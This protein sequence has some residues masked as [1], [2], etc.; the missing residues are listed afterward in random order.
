MNKNGV[1]FDVRDMTIYRGYIIDSNTYYDVLKRLDTLGESGE[2]VSLYIREAKKYLVG[3]LFRKALEISRTMD[4]T[5]VK[6]TDGNYQY[7][8]DS[9]K[10][11]DLGDVLDEFEVHGKEYGIPKPKLDR[12]RDKLNRVIERRKN[13]YIGLHKMYSGENKSNG[14]K[15]N[16]NGN[17]HENGG[18]E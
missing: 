15:K 13:H 17:G 6:D 18:G 5:L 2:D 7:H 14:E 16:G 1:E 10:L 12:V 3:N 11:A 4:F 8:V 9:T